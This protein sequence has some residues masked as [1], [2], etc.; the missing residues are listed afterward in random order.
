MRCRSKLALAEVAQLFVRTQR[1]R[2]PVY[3]GSLDHIPGFVHIKDIFGVLLDRQRRLE[4]GRPAPPF[5]LRR[6]MREPL[7]RARAQTCLR[8][9][10][11]AALARE[12]AW[13]WSWTSSEV[14]SVS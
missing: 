1:S 4:Q 12:L 14:S 2:I 13:R 9:A 11:R 5:D 6:M 8:T 7:D 10:R 3:E